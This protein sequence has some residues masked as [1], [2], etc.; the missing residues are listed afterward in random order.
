[1]IRL[2]VAERK[3]KKMRTTSLLYDFQLLVDWHLKRASSLTSRIAYLFT[4]LSPYTYIMYNQP[5]VHFLIFF[6]RRYTRCKKTTVYAL[7]IHIFKFVL[8]N[9]L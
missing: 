7:V 6:L 8:S 4:G 1:M 9:P 3:K 2:V 5:V